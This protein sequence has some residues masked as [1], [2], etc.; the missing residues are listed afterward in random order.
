LAD[1]MPARTEDTPG[2]PGLQ[3]SLKQRHMTMISL[4]G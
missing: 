3:R 1:T 2:E 4:G